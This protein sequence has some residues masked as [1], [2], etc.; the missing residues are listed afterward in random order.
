MKTKSSRTYL[1]LRNH[2]TVIV[3]NHFLLSGG[4]RD[5]EKIRFNILEYFPMS[6]DEPLYYKLIEEFNRLGIKQGTDYTIT[7]HHNYLGFYE[8][9]AKS[10][11]VV[12]TA[13][14]LLE[15]NPNLTC[16]ELFRI[17]FGKPHQFYSDTE[18]F[19]QLLET[20]NENGYVEGIDY[21][22]IAKENHSV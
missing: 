13:N 21:S 10:I 22:N 17:E 3:A 9:T 15:T 20:M 18:L 14:R 1:Y 19:I 6:P 2:L 12:H 8:F 4:Y 7:D 5:I 16:D 11:K